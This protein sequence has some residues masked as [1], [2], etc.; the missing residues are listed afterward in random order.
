[1]ATTGAAPSPRASV[2]IAVRGSASGWRRFQRS[3]SSA[4]VR[5]FVHEVTAQV[6]AATSKRSARM[7]WASSAMRHI[8]PEK[9]SDARRPPSPGVSGAGAKR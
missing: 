9:H 6:S 2:T 8:G 7:R 3:A 5:R 1:M 4:S